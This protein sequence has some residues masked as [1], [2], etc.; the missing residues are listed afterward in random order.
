MIEHRSFWARRLHSL[1]GVIPIGAFLVE[2]FFT[3]SFSRQGPEASSFFVDEG[4]VPGLGQAF[5]LV[6]PAA[7]AGTDVY[8]ER[9][10]A[11]VD[12]MVVDPNVRLAGARRLALEREA[13]ERG[14]DVPVWL[15]QGA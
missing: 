2:H 7:L 12:A 1:S 10:E 14:I 11:L 3:N 5:L 6:D 9:V 8:A 15:M 13:R 4:N